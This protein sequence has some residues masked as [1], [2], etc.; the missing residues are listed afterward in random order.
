MMAGMIQRGDRHSGAGAEEE[1]ALKALAS[2]CGS[3][4]SPA[5]PV[6]PRSHLRTRPRRRLFASISWLTWNILLQLYN[7]NLE[8]SSAEFLSLYF[9]ILAYE[10]YAIQI[11]TKFGT[12]L[13]FLFLFLFPF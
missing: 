4:R 10:T 13:L 7:P 8:Q 11:A 6:T 12:S 3:H 9:E 1:G 5:R 2:N